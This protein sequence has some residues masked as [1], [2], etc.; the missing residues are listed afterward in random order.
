MPVNVI[1]YI[2]A[3]Q[4]DCNFVRMAYDYARMC[5]WLCSPM[6]C[7]QLVT[8]Y[9]CVYDYAHLSYAVSLWLCMHAHVTM[10]IYA[11]LLTCT[12][13]CMSMYAS[14]LVMHIYAM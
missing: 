6:L 14:A 9:A 5:V 2:Y 1:M 4:L 11:M 7:S 10:H 3:M 13:V 8:K 12:Y